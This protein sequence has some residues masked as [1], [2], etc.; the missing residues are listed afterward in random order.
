MFFLPDLS[1]SAFP[2]Y[3]SHFSCILFFILVFSSPGKDSEKIDYSVFSE[4]SIMHLFFHYF[5][6]YC[7]FQ[8]VN[9]CLFPSSSFSSQ[10]GGLPVPWLPWQPVPAGEGRLQAFQWVRR[11]LPPDA[12]HQAHPRHAVAP[13]RLLHHVLKVKPSEGQEER[14]W[15]RD[16]GRGWAKRWRGK[17]RR[18][19]EEGEEE[20]DSVI[21]SIVSQNLLKVW[22]QDGGKEVGYL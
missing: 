17:R 10:L 16:G 3:F 2:S 21:F 20:G 19:G 5:L 8:N 14:D 12:V 7:H 13:T 11:P 4:C 1:T 15:R 6:I 18:E 22:V 9:S